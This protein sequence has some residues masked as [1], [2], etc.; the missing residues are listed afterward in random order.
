MHIEHNTNTNAHLGTWMPMELIHSLVQTICALGTTHH[1]A[2][3]REF[4]WCAIGRYLACYIYECHFTQ[5]THDD[6]PL[7]GPLHA[8]TSSFYVYSHVY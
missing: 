2:T 1:Q 8:C 3:T 6:G 7:C 5:T 4:C